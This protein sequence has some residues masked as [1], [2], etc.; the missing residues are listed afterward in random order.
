MRPSPPERPEE[1]GDGPQEPEGDLNGGGSGTADQSN[2]NNPNS[3]PSPV[4][5]PEP[6][7]VIQFLHT[8]QTQLGVMQ[9]QFGVMQAHLEAM[10]GQ[11][12]EQ[13]PE[14]GVRAHDQQHQHT[15]R[16]P[17]P[18][19]PAFHPAAI[20]SQTS[21]GNK[22][23][24][25]TRAPTTPKRPRDVTSPP[26]PD[27]T[28]P[29]NKRPRK[30]MVAPPP[31]PAAT[32]FAPADSDRPKT[33]PGS[34]AQNNDAQGNA[35]PRQHQLPSWLNFARCIPSLPPLSLISFSASTAPTLRS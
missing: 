21:A 15:T 19:P 10:Q 23:E 28:I 5:Q 32:S 24:E 8:V 2:S 33:D 3:V 11:S 1:D 14:E 20:A 17:E 35:G 29:A 6:P 27:N 12:S 18:A 4:L 26:P 7:A 9:A 31:D 25:E 34:H 30:T 13:R 22:E 16:S